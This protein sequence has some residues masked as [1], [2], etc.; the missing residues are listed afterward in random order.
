MMTPAVRHIGD[1]PPSTL[2]AKRMIE[3]LH[4]AT[5]GGQRLRF[6]RTPI[7]DGRPDMPWHCVDD[8]HKCLG[9][10]R[11]QRKAFLHKL[12]NSNWP[13]KTIAVADGI[14]TVA[15][16]FVAQGTVDTWV[17]TGMAPKSVR[18]E[19]GDASTEALK[20]LPHLP[21][22]VNPEAFLLWLKAARDRWDEAWP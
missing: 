2:I 10:N 14:I 16:H 19:Y 11:E 17:D 22:A 6:F 15:P 21:A 4:I 7:N 5:V 1:K 9:L 20:K 3:P 18:D 8:L 13:T 12:K